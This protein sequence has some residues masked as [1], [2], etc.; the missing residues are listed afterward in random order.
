LRTNALEKLQTHI[1]KKSNRTLREETKQELVSKFIK[2]SHWKY[3][4]HVLRMDKRRLPLQAFNWTPVGTRMRGR[5]KET[6]RTTIARE[7]ANINVNTH[8]LHELA[9][10]RRCWRHMIS[11]LCAASGTG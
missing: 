10:D 6:L 2:R 1:G 4:G 5:P 11:A 8:D 3:L 9:K 7:S